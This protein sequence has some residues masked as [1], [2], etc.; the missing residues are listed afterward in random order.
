[1]KN[2][3]YKHYIAWGLTAFAVIGLSIL[4]FF[5]LYRVKG[6]GEALHVLTNILRPFIYGA[7]LAYVLNPIFRRCEGLLTTLLSPRFKKTGRAVY[8]A[9]FISTVITLVLTFVALFGLFYMVLPQLADSVVGIVKKM[10]DYLR[11]IR[12]WL[13]QLLASTPEAGPLDP[14]IMEAYQ[15]LADYAEQWRQTDLLPLLGGWAVLAYS[16][17]LIAVTGLLNLLI[18][19]IVM[20]YLLNAKQTFTAQCKKLFYSIFGPQ[21]GNAVIENIRYTHRVFGGFINGKLLDSLIVGIICFIFMAIT[22]MPYAMLI[23]VIIGVTNII[24]FFGPFLGA[25]PSALLLL[26]ESPLLCLYFLIFILILQQIDGNIL[27]PRILGG[28]TGLPSFWVLFSILLF[29]G[30]FGFVGMVVAVPL[31]ALIYSLAKA[32]IARG[33]KKW[34]LPHDTGSYNDLHHVEEEGHALVKNSDM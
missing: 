5:I 14:L 25:I 7:A 1:M 19:V 31:F 22:N 12:L 4:L 32:L 13:D 20:V 16:G 17:I 28:A 33:L 27:G 34:E 26:F 10:P 2:T 9:R 23:S 6:V 29:G 15:S 8:W 21:R 18:G 30:L 3:T 24:P 11:E